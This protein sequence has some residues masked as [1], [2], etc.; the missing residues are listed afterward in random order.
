MNFEIRPCD[1]SEL[2]LLATQTI[3]REYANSLEIDLC[4]QGFDEELNHLTQIYSKPQGNIWLVWQ[5]QEVAG[6]IAV[7]RLDEKNCEMKRLYLT[8]SARG[9]GLAKQLINSA[10]GF[11]REANYQ[12]M[13]LDT[14]SS[15]TAAIQLYLN[16]GFVSTHQYVHNPIETALFFEKRLL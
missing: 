5:N 1:F 12:T 14:L 13:K 8:P 4:F 9:K 7:K 6:S 15:M 3:F 16:F 2:E 11:A 10:I